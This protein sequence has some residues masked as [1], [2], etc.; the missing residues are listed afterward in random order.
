MPIDPLDWFQSITGFK[1]S[2]YADTRR[3]LAVEGDQLVRLADG[4]VL[5]STGRFGTPTLADLRG[6]AN[7]DLGRRTTVRCLVGEA[8]AL[9]R[10]AEFADALFQVASQ[11]NCLE[12]VCPQVTPEA[13]V[14]RY[15]GD[16]TQGPA[17]A[18]AAGLGTIYRNYFAPVG[19]QI[20][21]TA[22]RQIDNLADVGQ[23][24]AEL[25]GRR[26]SSLWTMTNG[27]CDASAEQLQAINAALA[28]S[29]AEEVDALRAG[30]RIG[31]HHDLEVTDVA[32]AP[33]PQVAQAYCSAV[34]VGY[35]RQPPQA[36][37][38][39]AR[40]VLEASYEATLLAAAERAAAGHS[41][42]V[43]LTRIGGGVFRNKDAWITDAVVRALRIVE[44]ASLDVR[45][46]SHGFVNP[47]TA[48]IERDW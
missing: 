11:F 27:Y 21:Q 3:R 37:Q 40:L 36:W 41:P 26:G 46:V 34:P 31:L 43:L 42:V 12:M 23:R 5:G 1:E 14:T 24:L 44:N 28:R 20:G 35:S 39:F 13:G 30:L 38:P 17:C 22:G 25:M 6:R 16:A 9:H 29:S 48:R 2:D 32:A 15:A 47:E 7:T 4:Q 8:R 45:L 33:R 19:D 10:Q 18:I